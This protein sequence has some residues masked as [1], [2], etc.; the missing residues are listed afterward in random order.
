MSQLEAEVEANEEQEKKYLK[1]LEVVQESYEAMG[2]EMEGLEDEA[3][4]LY[5]QMKEQEGLIKEL[6]SQSG[7]GNLAMFGGK[8][9]ALVARVR[10]AKEKGL[11]RGNVYGPVGALL[12]MKTGKESWAKLAEK[13]I[14]HLALATFICDNQVIIGEPVTLSRSGCLHSI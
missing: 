12:K 7:A 3:K 11:L 6:N 5:A 4:R 2:E 14:G 9:P 13:A 1:K 8:A 10:A